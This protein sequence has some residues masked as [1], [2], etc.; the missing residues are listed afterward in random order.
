MM[1]EMGMA[2]TPVSVAA[3]YGDLLDGFV[4]D[5]RDEAIIDELGEVSSARLVQSTETWMKDDNDKTALAE[6]V[7]D[8]AK[9]LTQ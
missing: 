9:R 7:L 6:F 3:H 1:R 4:V 8:M 5:Y 2:V